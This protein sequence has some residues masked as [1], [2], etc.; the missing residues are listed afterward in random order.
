MIPPPYPFSINADDI[1]LFDVK[2]AFE[3][4]V[5]PLKYVFAF[6]MVRFGIAGAVGGTK[7]LVYSVILGITRTSLI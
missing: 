7:L 2:L 3:A 1:T 6:D 5:F 4:I